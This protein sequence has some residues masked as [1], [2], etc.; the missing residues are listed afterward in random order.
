MSF[1]CDGCGEPAPNGT[2]QHKRVVKTRDKVYTR[3][4]ETKHGLREVV[5]GLGKET[6]KE[7]NF[8]EKCAEA[9]D[10]LD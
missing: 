7:A 2:K 1:I 6:V 5:V 8:C 10:N 9:V 4:M 3:T